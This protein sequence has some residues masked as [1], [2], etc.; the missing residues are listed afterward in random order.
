M[1]ERA[2]A[3]VYRRMFR[4]YP[5][6]GR[7]LDLRGLDRLASGRRRLVPYAGG[8]IAGGK[9]RLRDCDIR[10]VSKQKFAPL[11]PFVLRNASVSKH[12][13]RER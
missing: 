4:L 9:S 5:A 8:S 7:R 1:A 10:L 12:E 6:Q 11:D 2:P 13:H 3:E